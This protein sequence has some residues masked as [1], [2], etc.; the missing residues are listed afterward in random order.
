VDLLTAMDVIA[1]GLDAQRTRMN[2]VASNLANAQTTRTAQGGPYRRLDPVLA[3]RPLPFAQALRDPVAAQVR[4]V[5]VVA[6]VEDS[7]P[8]HLV[9]DPGHPDADAKGNV[10]YPNIKLV[11]QM[12]HLIAAARAYEANVTA[13]Q[14]VRGM[15]ERALGIGR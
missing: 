7:S 14:S 3:A 15:A 1:S 12:V 11:E 8:P 2:L 5:D 13:M 4:T 6:V 10:A 9:H